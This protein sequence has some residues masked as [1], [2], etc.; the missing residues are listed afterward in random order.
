MKSKTF[1]PIVRRAAG[2]DC[3]LHDAAE[4]R[5]ASKFSAPKV[6]A[7]TASWCGPCNVPSRSWS[8]FRLWG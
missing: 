5:A 8:K 1:D 4:A 2:I 7:F 6:L 3:R